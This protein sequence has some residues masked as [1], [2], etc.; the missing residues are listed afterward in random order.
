M[1]VYPHDLY[2]VSFAYVHY[3]YSVPCYGSSYV[4]VVF[5]RQSYPAFCY[6][7]FVSFGGRRPRNVVYYHC[8]ILFVP[9]R[10]AGHHHHHH[11][12][13]YYY[14]FDVEC[15][16]VYQVY[17]S[18]P[19]SLYMCVWISYQMHVSSLMMNYYY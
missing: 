15:T 11:H 1:H 17:D 9:R 2:C 13:Y 3:V 18:S 19:Q 14:S 5:V 16:P 7:W 4:D 8:H 6:V 10:I 12:Y